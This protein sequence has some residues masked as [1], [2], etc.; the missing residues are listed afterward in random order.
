M[1]KFNLK[2]EMKNQEF[3]NEV[4][5]KISG[6]T[7]QQVQQYLLSIYN[8]REPSLESDS[9][10]LMSCPIYHM[11]KEREQ[12]I[13][14]QV[15][16]VD[17]VDGKDY[18]LIEK[19]YYYLEEC[20]HCNKKHIPVRY[21]KEQ[22]LLLL[23]FNCFHRARGLPEYFLMGINEDDNDQKYFIH[24]LWLI[25]DILVSKNELKEIL[26]WVNRVDEGYEGRIQGDIIY[27]FAKIQDHICDPKVSC[28]CQGKGCDYKNIV[29]KDVLILWYIIPFLYDKDFRKNSEL[30]RYVK[31]KNVE[32]VNLEKL[33][34]ENLKRISIGNSHS[35]STDG[36][37]ARSSKL[38]PRNVFMII[39]GSYVL[40][41]HPEHK[42][43]TK[44]IPN[45]M[46]LIL[47]IQR[48]SV[49][50]GLDD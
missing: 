3:Y 4:I 46:A 27:Q 14:H 17:R 29:F 30:P 15:L 43:V 22:L 11:Q 33:R 36:Y 39:G 32:V 23:Q 13:T 49:N 12:E 34:Q 7:R 6:E 25:P 28:N 38:G 1:V 16:A 37:I 41:E 50:N 40:L 24:P 31:I 35:I 2:P 21:T 9:I 20:R 18:A 45:G 26:E 44:D 8:I 42:A 10:T 5:G 19:I 47:T 48:G